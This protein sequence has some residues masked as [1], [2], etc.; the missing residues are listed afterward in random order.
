MR[1][2]PVEH[3]YGKPKPYPVSFGILKGYRK[4]PYGEYTWGNYKGYH[5]RIIDYSKYDQK[6][7]YVSDSKLHKW[8]MS[9]LSYVQNGIRQV[10]RSKAK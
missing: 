1:I 4:I 5:I 8:I 2:K 10:M 9:K 7:I 3:K 6:L